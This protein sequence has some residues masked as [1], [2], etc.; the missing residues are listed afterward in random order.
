MD[1]D[2]IRVEAPF[3]NVPK[4]CRLRVTKELCR[5]HILK[6]RKFSPQNPCDVCVV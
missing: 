2:M 6:P 3:D 4:K 1:V 5:K